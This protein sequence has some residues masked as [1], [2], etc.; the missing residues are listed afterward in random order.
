MFFLPFYREDFQLLTVPEA[1]MTIPRP[2][3]TAY[4][5]ICLE[6]VHFIRHIN[7]PQLWPFKF[8]VVNLLKLALR[9]LPSAHDSPSERIDKNFR[10]VGPLT[11]DGILHPPMNF[12]NY[13]S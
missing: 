9:A 8:A 11:S 12:L 6:S 10:G 2:G 3:L 7:N 1:G 13:A 4:I 5:H